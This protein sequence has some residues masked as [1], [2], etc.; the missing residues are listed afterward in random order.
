[1]QLKVLQAIVSN[2]QMQTLK[3]EVLGVKANRQKWYLVNQYQL[4]PI[5]VA[6]QG[7][8]RHQLLSIKMS[9]SL[10]RHQVPFMKLLSIHLD[11]KKM[12]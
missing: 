1:M 2:M 3:W 9:S 12:S 11:A 8:N 5:E 4:Y 7:K 6:A 10:T